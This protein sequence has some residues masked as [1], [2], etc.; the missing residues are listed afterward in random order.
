MIQGYVRLIF[1]H[2][3]APASTK[4]R[5]FG[6]GCRRCAYR[7]RIGADAERIRRQHA[8][9]QSVVSFAAERNAPVDAFGDQIDDRSVKVAWMENIRPVGEKV[10]IS[11]TT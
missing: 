9:H 1:T 4:H 11:G 2:A 3:A 5:T 6:A 7:A 10:S 8:T